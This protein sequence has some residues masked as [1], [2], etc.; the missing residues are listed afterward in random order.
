[1]NHKSDSLRIGIV[2]FPTFGGSGVVASELARTLAESGH[3]VHVISQSRPVRLRAFSPNVIYHEIPTFEY[4]LFDAPLYALHTAATI[5]NL[6][7]Y[8]ELDIIHAH[9]ALPHAV[10]ALLARLAKPNARFR[11]VTTLH[12][13]DVTLLG[14]DPSFFPITRYAIH[15]S[16]AVTCVSRYLSRILVEDY[17]VPQNQIFHIPNFVDT[18]TFKPAPFEHRMHNWENRKCIVH[19]SN[20][21]PVKRTLDVVKIFN[22]VAREIN[23]ELVM[24]GDGPDRLRCER[25]CLEHNLKDRVRFLGKQDDI[26]PVLQNASVFLIPSELESFGLA[27]LEAMS[28]A[29]PVVATRVGGIPELITDG[30]EGFL[31]DVGDIDT[32]ANAVRRIL[33]HRELYQTLSDAARRRAENF[34]RTRVVARYE[35]LYLSLLNAVHPEPD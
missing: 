15:H 3:E 2:C 14:R 27:A 23:A 17:G 28:C 16:D 5:A 9:Y 6:T 10:S 8:V 4:P 29:V 32:M 13:T 18:R 19:V 1:M 11:I 31:A 30:K 22:K 24:V 26:V 34:E 35:N 12:G 33:T 25:Y 20:F 21:R 7:D